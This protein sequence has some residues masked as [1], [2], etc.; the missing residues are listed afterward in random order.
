[1]EFSR[2][3]LLGAVEPFK[4]QQQVVETADSYDESD[5]IKGRSCHDKIQNPKVVPQVHS[6]PL[7]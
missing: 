3:T 1:M 5:D 4:H 7:H 6:H 2:V